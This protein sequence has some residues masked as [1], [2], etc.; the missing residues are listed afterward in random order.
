MS[1][2]THNGRFIVNLGGMSVTRD[3]LDAIKLAHSRLE[4]DQDAVDYLIQIAERA[5]EGAI[6]TSECIAHSDEYD[7][8]GREYVSPYDHLSTAYC[9][10]IKR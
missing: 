7:G 1:Y 4:T 2:Y 9:D 6:E 8:G 5:F 10:A 3:Q